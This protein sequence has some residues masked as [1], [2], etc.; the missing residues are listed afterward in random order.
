MKSHIHGGP[1]AIILTA[2]FSPLYIFL[3]DAT[4][5]GVVWPKVLRGRVGR[6][7]D[8]FTEWQHALKRRSWTVGRTQRCIYV[9]RSIA[10]ERLLIETILHQNCAQ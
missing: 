1:E 7:L 10:S 6:E 2:I 9:F 8:N 3:S 4:F 5:G